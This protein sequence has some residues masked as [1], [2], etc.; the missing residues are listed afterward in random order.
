MGKTSSHLE[1]KALNLRRRQR[2]STLNKPYDLKG[3]GDIF[4]AS[5]DGIVDMTSKTSQEHAYFHA[6]F[7]GSSARRKVVLSR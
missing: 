2:R 6:I 1:K 3:D 5:S 7:L 4:Q